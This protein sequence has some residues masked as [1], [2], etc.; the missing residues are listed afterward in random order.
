IDLV[1]SPS[2]SS[3]EVDGESTTAMRLGVE[4]R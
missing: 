1:C 3:V 4:V 2:F